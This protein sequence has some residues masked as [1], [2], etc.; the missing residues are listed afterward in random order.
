MNK[1]LFCIDAGFTH[2]GMSLFK[3]NNG[4]FIFQA[5]HTV[6]TEKSDKKK[7]IR[8]ADDDAERTKLIIKGMKKFI[9]P[10]INDKIMAAV[11]L[12]TGG[13]RGARANRTMGIVAG[14]IVTFLELMEWPTEYVSPNDVKIAI[15]GNKKASKEVIMNK[16]RK[17]LKRHDHLLPSTKG[18]FEHV[19]DSIGCA[20]HIKRHSEMF[21]AFTIR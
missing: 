13:A 7:Q 5:A 3:V 4:K 16:V 14:A 21:R 8:V 18:E 6:V 17:I 1:Y 12:P 9:T 11:E 10:Y 15:A 2:T 19:A 20:V